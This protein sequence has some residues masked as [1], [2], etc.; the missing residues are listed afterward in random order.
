MTE[1]RLVIF[2]CD[3]VL[4]DS[5]PISNRLLAE[6]IA[7]AGLPMDAEGVVE[8]FEGMRLGDIQAAVERRLDRPLPDGW[9]AGFEARRAAAFEQELTP[10]P[11]VADAL[12]QLSAAAT[13][14]CVASQASVEKME[15][16]LSL[17]GLRDHF[18]GSALFSSAMVENGKPDPAL[19]LLAAESIGFEPDKCMVVEDGVPGVEAAQ[20]AGMAV[21]GYGP[22]L[23]GERLQRAGARV[24]TSMADLPR[25]LSVG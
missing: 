21:L 9:L 3:G 20:R 12:V 14:M 23:R 17:T 11:G 5:E 22:G 13:P 25:L 2:D 6:E 16:T 4:V 24:F 19:F 10:I 18:P 15:L 7:A 1:R 8:T